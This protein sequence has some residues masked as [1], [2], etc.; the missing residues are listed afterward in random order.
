MRV[1]ARCFATKASGASRGAGDDF[2]PF[3]GQEGLG[4]LPQGAGD[5]VGDAQVIQP[6][7]KDIKSTQIYAHLSADHLR[8]AAGKVRVG[9][10]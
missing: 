9:E 1:L 2:D 5:D 8:E 6:G 4:P 3:F 7:H 10:E